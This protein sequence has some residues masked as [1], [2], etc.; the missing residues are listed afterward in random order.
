VTRSLSF[1]IAAALVTTSPAIAKRVTWRGKVV[2]VD[3]D[4]ITVL[5]DRRP[6]RIRL[7]RVDC[8]EQAQP[9]GQRAKQ[10]TAKLVFGNVVTV[11]VVTIGTC[12]RT[13]ATVLLGGK[14]LGDELVKAGLA[15]HYRKYSKS[16]KLAQ[17]EAAAREAKRGLWADP[18]PIAPWAWRRGV[19]S[20]P[21]RE[22]ARRCYQDCLRRNQAK[23][24]AWQQ[25]KRECR[26][27]C[28]L[29]APQ[30]LHGDVKSKVFHAFG[31]LRCRCKGCTRIF[32]NVAAAKKAG[33]RP[34]KACVDRRTKARKHP[35]RAA[36]S[37]DL[38]C[39]T[40]SDCVFL[41][42]VCYV[43]PACEPRWRPVVSQRWVRRQRKKKPNQSL[44]SVPKC[45]RCSGK[46]GWIGTKA[47]CV[48]R[49]C[50]V[51]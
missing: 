11:E 9:F 41:S 14:S 19:R 39:K 34:H 45:R 47:V 21:S 4:K 1:V 13:I 28:G 20:S 38:V 49:Q 27:R 44:C 3:G 37:K 24:V 18:N 40:D 33:Y 32:R 51:R 5:H 10:F 48:K 36:W 8:P 12:G 23:A 43:C 31:C 16:R 22:K 7:H 26:G 17:F 50:T 6:V 25:I 35:P 15:W 42:T 29:M 30:V 2:G 46:G